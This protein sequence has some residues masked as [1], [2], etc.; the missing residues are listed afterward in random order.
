MRDNADAIHAE[1][2][3]AAVLFVIRLVLNRPN[4][5][6]PEECAGFSQRCAHKLV[7]EPFKHCHS[8]R[9]AR[10]QDHVANESIANDNFN[11]IFKQMTA[12]NVA[13]KVKRT[14]FQQLE[15]FLGQ[16]GTL[17]VLVAKRDQ[18]NGWVLIM[19][20]MTR[21]DRAHERVLKKMLRAG[22]DVRACINQNEDIRFGRKHGRDAWSIDSWQRAKLNRAR[23]NRRARVTCAHYCIRLASFH[24]I[25]GAAY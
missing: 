25:E 6:P 16:L 24:E 1:K 20:N 12:L 4:C 21:V 15:H 17:H 13:N 3:A 10:F 18:A 5:I 9:F 23:G 7:L 22:I 2:W 14:W 19:E 8:D 11:R